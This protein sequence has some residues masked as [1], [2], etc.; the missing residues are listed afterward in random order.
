MLPRYLECT[1]CGE[2][3]YFPT[4]DRAYYIGNESYPAAVND[5]E[6]LRMLL[7]PIWCWECSKPSWVEVVPLLSQLEK[8][9]ALVKAKKEIKFPF[10]NEFM[11]Q[12]ESISYLN[13]Y[14]NWVQKRKSKGKCVL[15]SNSNYTVLGGTPVKLKHEHCEYGVFKPCYPIFSS[16]KRMQTLIYDTEGEEIGKL[17]LWREELDGWS[18]LEKEKNV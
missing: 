6:L 15:C 9:F 3:L 4:E 5:K 1:E 2:K 12:E 16:N 10:D 17:S 8:S 11:N 18:F 13:M 14:L 7:D